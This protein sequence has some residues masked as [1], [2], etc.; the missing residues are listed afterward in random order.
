MLGCWEGFRSELETYLF[1]LLWW[2]SAVLQ[3]FEVYSLILN[4]V[5]Y[6]WIYTFVHDFK[7]LRKGPNKRIDSNNSKERIPQLLLIGS[8]KWPPVYYKLTC[9]G[10]ELIST[11]PWSWN[12]K[13]HSRLDM[14]LSEENV[15]FIIWN[16]NLDLLWGPILF[17][18]EEQSWK[19]HV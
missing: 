13:P 15:C 9:S 12:S 3:G 5:N 19:E 11:S 6:F 7:P 17:P 14:V 1:F 16:K 2:G 18:Y 10:L 4:R 8:R